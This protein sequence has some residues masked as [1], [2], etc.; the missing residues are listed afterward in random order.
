LSENWPYCGAPLPPN[1][2]FEHIKNCPVLRTKR[3][4]AFALGKVPYEEGELPD[5]LEEVIRCKGS[6]LTDD[7][8]FVG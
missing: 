3:Q 2:T 4:I 5:Y 1:E 6:F 8:V 7:V